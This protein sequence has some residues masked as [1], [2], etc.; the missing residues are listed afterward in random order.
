MEPSTFSAELP[1]LSTLEP[2]AWV[3]AMRALRAH[4][5]DSAAYI[6]D[7]EDTPESAL[8]KLQPIFDAYTSLD[9]N[10]HSEDRPESPLYIDMKVNADALVFWVFPTRSYESIVYTDA[11]Y[12]WLNDAGADDA[13]ATHHQLHRALILRL[14]KMIP[15]ADDDNLDE[16]AAIEAAT[17]AG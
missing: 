17:R 8:P 4:V 6:L 16:I 14:L 11:G 1:T 3:T 5:A 10:E 15:W 12:W 7:Y 13:E 9:I 2:R